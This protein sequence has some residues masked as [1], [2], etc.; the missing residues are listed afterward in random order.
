[1]DRRWERQGPEKIPP[2]LQEEGLLHRA[3]RS[4]LNSS[5]KVSGCA[6]TS[7]PSALSL[8]PFSSGR[9][10]TSRSHFD[11]K[12]N[13]ALQSQGSDFSPVSARQVLCP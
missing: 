9:N 8:H 10:M 4:W 12:F 7:Q 6:L 13:L 11:F 2:Y 5:W 3:G 1:M